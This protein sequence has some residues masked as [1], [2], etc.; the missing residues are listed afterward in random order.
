[1]L[2]REAVDA[3]VSIFPVGERPHVIWLEQRVSAHAIVGED[4]GG[5]LD[6]AAWFPQAKL[7]LVTDAKFGARPVDIGSREHPNRQIEGYAILAMQS[8]MRRVV[9]DGYREIE[10]VRL[11]I[12]APSAFAGGKVKYVDLP[13]AS[14]EERAARLTTEVARARASHLSHTVPGRHCG[15]C[16]ARL[17]CSSHDL[18]LL[19]AKEFQQ[20]GALRDFEVLLHDYAVLT[21]MYK[22]VELKR[23]PTLSF[24]HATLSE[25]FM[26]QYMNDPRLRIVQLKRSRRVDYYSHDEL[27]RAG[28]K[29]A[30]EQQATRAMCDKLFKAA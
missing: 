4:V 1:M 26:A 19:R 29:K 5:T 22:A 25:L 30:D 28:E 17:T 20:F 23:E 13:F 11:A 27:E 9:F 6:V 18:T 12:L 7:F 14:F 21:Q 10:T 2:A 8:L 3:L 15:H 16:P 24:Y